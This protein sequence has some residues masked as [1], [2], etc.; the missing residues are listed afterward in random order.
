MRTASRLLPRLA[1][2][3]V[4]CLFAVTSPLGSTPAIAQSEGTDAEPP[5]VPCD[6]GLAVSY[7]RGDWGTISEA[8]L[9]DNSELLLP[10]AGDRSSETP[11]IVVTATSTSP[12]TFESRSDEAGSTQIVGQTNEVGGQ[13]S[14]TFEHA[15]P[16]GGQVSVHLTGN[17]GATVSI[18]GSE[19]DST[20]ISVD[21]PWALD[22]SGRP[23][24]TWYEVVDGGF[25]QVVDTSGA[26]P[27]V[28]F[29]PT[30]SAMNCSS[31]YWSWLTAG[32]YLDMYAANTDYGFCP[33]HG[34]FLAVRPYLPVW[35]FETNVANDF[36]LI[37]VRQDG[38]CTSSPDTGWAWDFQVPCKAHDY[39]YDLRVAG[40]SGTVTDNDCD[41]AFYWIMEAHCNNRVLSGD[42][43][44]VRD[45]YY[46][47]VAAPGVV[48]DPN[49]GLV[50]IRNFA[51]NKCLDVEGP[52]SANGTPL[53]QWDC[54]GVSNQRFR[55]SPVGSGLFQVTMTW[56]SGRC[57]ASSSTVTQQA[58][59]TS[60][61]SQ[62]LRIQGV[63]GSN[64]YT[65]RA[66]V[67]GFNECWKVP[68]SSSNGVDLVDPTCNDGNGYFRWRINHV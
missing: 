60:S 49:P 64:I 15:A 43:R 3:L 37:P 55:I 27:P 2:A 22:A 16:C 14:A 24:S 32:Q 54:V 38:D 47:V 57:A 53:Q 6:G 58:C 28:T 65:F 8:A 10:L 52:S 50:S 56:I 1:M 33:I 19:S 36:G 17:G 67:A 13:I 62:R 25:R 18:T 44:I 21:R 7:D 46:L 9:A 12:T 42:C 45:T 35:A 66:E 20:V 31:G 26:V 40:F 61:T 4:S 29:D 30:Y 68:D 59:S 63:S 23:L 39:C 11:S 34:M 48:A 5:A 51:T 41:V